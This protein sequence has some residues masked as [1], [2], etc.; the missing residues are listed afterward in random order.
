MNSEVIK[1]IEEIKE[2]PNRA[3]RNTK[4][5]I[6][7]ELE[8]VS[9]IPRKVYHEA[10]IGCITYQVVDLETKNP[11]VE[12]KVSKFLKQGGKSTVVCNSIYGAL[13][14]LFGV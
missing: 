5:R 2:N 3:Y 6:L 9:D 10:G 1:A 14:F 11:K 12:F 4:I 13:E 8:N 7:E